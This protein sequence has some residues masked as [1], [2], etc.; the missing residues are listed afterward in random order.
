[1][2]IN[3]RDGDVG[4][5]GRGGI[6]ESSRVAFHWIRFR[7]D[8]L[9]DIYLDIYLI[10]GPLIWLMK[11][12]RGHSNLLIFALLISYRSGRLDVDS[13]PWWDWLVVEFHIVVNSNW[14]RCRLFETVDC[15]RSFLG[16][17]RHRQDHRGTAWRDESM[18]LFLSLLSSA[19]TYTPILCTPSAATLG[20]PTGSCTKWRTWRTLRAI[21]PPSTRPYRS[22]PIRMPAST[23]WPTCHW[24][25]SDPC[26][27]SIRIAL[28]G[29]K[30][31]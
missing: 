18:G 29:K 4:G 3:L 27:L 16:C 2:A 21:I 28:V 11:F 7:C 14:S 31:M 20:W 5:R 6:C 15:G 13:S 9:S 1:M 22:R 26:S 30:T 24:D 10:Q 25:R 19:A 17:F 8:I 12:V 23:S